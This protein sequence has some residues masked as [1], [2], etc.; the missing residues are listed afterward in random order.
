MFCMAC[1]QELSDKATFCSRCGR[2]VASSEALRAAKPSIMELQCPRC[3]AKLD[4]S[5]E[6]TT[7]TCTSCGSGLLIAED[8]RIVTLNDGGRRLT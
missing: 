3:S 4:V 5:P 8:N 1:G 6:M 2:A 7:C